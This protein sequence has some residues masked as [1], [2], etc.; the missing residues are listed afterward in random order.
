MKLNY[1]S[2]K[3]NFFALT[4]R[5]LE[6]S[7]VIVASII[8]AHFFAPEDFGRYS[9]IIGISSVIAVI[10][11]FRLQSVMTKEILQ[12]PKNIGEILGS[13]MSANIGF[14]VLGFLIAALYLAFES[15]KLIVFCTLIYMISF[16]YKTPRA[17]RA[18]FISTEKNL[19]IAKCE[20]AA[21]L[22]SFAIILTFVALKLSLAWVIF[23]RSLDFLVSGILLMI[24]FK[25]EAKGKINLSSRF[26]TAKSMIKLSAP[27]VF[28]GA[29]M[30]LLQRMDLILVRQFLGDHAAGLYSSAATA[31]ALFSI[32]PLVISET[33][34]PRIFHKASGV[35]TLQAQQRFSDIVVFT[36]MIMSLFMAAIT[37]LFI[38]LLYGT[39][40]LGAHQAMLILSACPVLI[41]LG[42]ASGQI[43]VADGN[44]NQSF[45]KSIVAC[46]IN[47]ILNLTLIP[48]LGINGAAISTVTGLLIANLISHRFMPIYRYLFMMQTRSLFPLHLLRKIA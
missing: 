14:S 9:Y 26:A 44:Q 13:A 24:A 35:Q 16:F 15:D 10:A 30:L 41:A 33:L 34:A 5:A 46:S 37:P 4:A 1:A 20:I 21:S 47:L 40:Y 31:M 38:R 29:A 8:V 43:I 11:E 36:G 2:I 28:S 22:I 19:V 25:L 42:A 23:A 3:N 6:G 17:F 12:K 48:S 32:I 27:L 18:Y 7:K 39:E 45:I